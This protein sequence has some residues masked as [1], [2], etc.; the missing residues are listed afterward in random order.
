MLIGVDP[1]EFELLR[2]KAGQVPVDVITEQWTGI[3]F[4][5]LAMPA[6][7]SMGALQQWLGKLIVSARGSMQANNGNFLMLNCLSFY[8]IVVKATGFMS[9]FPKA[10]VCIG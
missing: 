9:I 8:K 1:D 7:T 5:L 6:G 4:D 2:L 3:I 10:F